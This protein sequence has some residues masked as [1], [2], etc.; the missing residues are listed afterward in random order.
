MLSKLE[1][2]LELKVT[3]KEISAKEK[4]EYLSTAKRARKIRQ[5]LI[6]GNRELVRLKDTIL[7]KKLRNLD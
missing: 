5:S 4:E 2:I 1:T 3:N 6:E 7:K